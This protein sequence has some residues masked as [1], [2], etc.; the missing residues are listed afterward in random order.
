[1]VQAD[2]VR[3]RAA[4]DEVD[5]PRAQAG[6]N[7]QH[8]LTT[9][10]GEYLDSAEADLP[11]A[12]IV[13]I[14]REFKI[15]EPSARAALTRL[16]RRGLIAMRDHS[17][18]PVYH[19]TPQA[20]TRHHRRMRH[21]LTFGA[22]APRWTGEWTVV[23]FSLP[24]PR[25]A[26]RHRLRKS[27]GALGFVR[28]YDSVWI[29]PGDDRGGVSAALR[30]ILDGTEPVRWSVM[31]ASFD[32]EAGPHGPTAAYDLDGLAAGYQAFINRY[33]P[34]RDSVRRGEVDAAQALVERTS[35]MDSWRTFADTDPNLP[36]HLLPEAWPLRTAREIFLEIHTALGPLAKARLVAVTTPY[37]PAAG[38]WFTH[39]QAPAGT[40]TFTHEVA[41]PGSNG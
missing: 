7:P 11:S 9:V 28:L 37:W 30:E 31:C 36:S 15:S 14:L 8:L 27:L 22:Q 17:R 32:D 12:A 1:M 2:W 39:F 3:A 10:L 41:V 4:E 20:I 16:T 6:P 33:G 18:P 40:A 13:A 35:L 19:L 23:S 21:F 5:A 24:E 29:R 25:Q 34:L 38:N 26:Q